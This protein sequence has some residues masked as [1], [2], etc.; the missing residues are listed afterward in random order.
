[1]YSSIDEAVRI[2]NG[3]VW[4]AFWNSLCNSHVGVGNMEGHLGKA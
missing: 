4:M 2:S 1:M 3:R